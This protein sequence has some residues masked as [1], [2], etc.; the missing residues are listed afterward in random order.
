M[1]SPAIVPTIS[2]HA[3]RSSAIPTLFASPGGV[4]TT[5]SASPAGLRGQHALGDPHL[6][7][8]ARATMP[9]PGD[10]CPPL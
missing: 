6:I 3:S 10:R 4:C 5:T 9:A 2:G 8:I 1:S 7:R